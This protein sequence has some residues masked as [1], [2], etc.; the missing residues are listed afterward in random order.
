[1]KLR[2]EGHPN[3]VRD[4]KTNAIISNDKAGYE[5]YINEKNFRASLLETRRE[6]DSLK[7]DLAEIKNILKIIVERKV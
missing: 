6:M 4:S 3:L 7:N 2:V 1:M 5:N